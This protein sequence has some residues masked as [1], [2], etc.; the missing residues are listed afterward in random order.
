[1][2]STV[3][4]TLFILIV[5]SSLHAMGMDT[6]HQ[7]IVRKACTMLDE[8]SS[9]INANH[10][11]FNQI[12]IVQK[13]VWRNKLASLPE[14]IK[15]FKPADDRNRGARFF[16]KTIL[17][18]LQEFNT[19]LTTLQHEQEI[20][21]KKSQ[22]KTHIEAIKAQLTTLKADGTQAPQTTNYFGLIFILMFASIASMASYYLLK[23]KQ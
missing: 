22:I 19:S 4:K 16:G 10:L 14:H 18:I 12:S 6:D 2:K 21:Y 3:K 13:L 5:A 11:Y 17:E 7:K 8:V 20:A 1:M 15:N 9:A 23:M